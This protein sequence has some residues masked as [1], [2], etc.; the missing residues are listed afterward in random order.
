MMICPFFISLQ[1]KIRISDC[2]ESFVDFSIRNSLFFWPDLLNRIT[3]ADLKNRSFIHKRR[4][5]IFQ[6]LNLFPWDQFKLPLQ[7]IK[8]TFADFRKDTKL[9]RGKGG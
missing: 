6:K 2:A 7:D 4:T 9:L 8:E 1:F 3:Q 5:E